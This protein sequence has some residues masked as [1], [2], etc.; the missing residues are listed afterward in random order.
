[1]VGS[2]GN[3]LKYAYT[4]DLKKKKKMSR[5]GYQPSEQKKIPTKREIQLCSETVLQRMK[6]EKAGGRK[7]LGDFSINALGGTS[8]FFLKSLRW[9]NEKGESKREDL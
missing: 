9:S 4:R 7:S 1:V 6:V 3:R 5:T 2:K 8:L